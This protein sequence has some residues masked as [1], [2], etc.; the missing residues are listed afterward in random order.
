MATMLGLGL[1]GYG[2][3]CAL[4]YAR[5]DS[6]LYF[7]DPGLVLTPSD[8]GLE[9]E[10]FEL[11]TPGGTVTGWT[12]RAPE[13]DAP[14]VLVFHG[15]AGNISYHI[16]HLPF[17]HQLGFNAVLFDYRGYGKSRGVPSEAG[18]VEDSLAV[19]AYLLE[20]EG[21][22]PGKL[23]YLGESLGGGVAA[24]T[25]EAADAPAGL[26]L[27]STFTSVPARASEAFP[28]LP[29]SLLARTRLD[30]AS[31]IGSFTFPILI[32]HGRADEIIGFSHGQTLYEKA[33]EPKAWLEIPGTHNTRPR[34]LGPEFSARVHEFVLTATGTGP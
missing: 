8:L 5:Q 15:N 10:D 11:P 29:I 1:L 31:R 3:L 33:N 13:P 18:L 7:P 9:F 24:A 19:R 22:P 6:M 2:A 14:W 25:A 12:V 26:I 30:T 28:Y 4:V 20:K 17:L 16:D 21:V 23:V 27:K 34:D 32:A